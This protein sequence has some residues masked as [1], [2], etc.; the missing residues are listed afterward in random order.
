MVCTF[1]NFRSRTIINY[2][3]GNFEIEVSTLFQQNLVRWYLSYKLSLRDLPE[4][5]LERGF[6]FSHEAV[7]SWILRFTPRLVSEMRKRRRGKAGLS[8]YVD[9]TYIKVRG[10]WTYLYRAI[11][12]DGV[13]YS[14]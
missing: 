6:Q 3:P 4:I 2:S 8:W 1:R 5:F 14:I 11:D 10:K 12:R 13:H 9:E 7:R